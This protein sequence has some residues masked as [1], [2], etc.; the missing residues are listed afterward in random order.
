MKKW[1]EFQD[2]FHKSKC[3]KNKEIDDLDLE[4]FIHFNI[5]NEP[6]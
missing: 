5:D 3:L 1:F 6:Q 4:N 2:K